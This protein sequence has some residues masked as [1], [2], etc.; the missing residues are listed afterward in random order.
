MEC[1]NNKI[2]VLFTHWDNENN[3]GAEPIAASYDPRPLRKQMIELSDK[4]KTEVEAQY[5]KDIWQEDYTWHSDD[6]VHLG[7]DQHTGQLANVWSWEIIQ[8]DIH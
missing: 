8:L 5:G 6:N 2:Y 3:E 4:L 7:F 1:S